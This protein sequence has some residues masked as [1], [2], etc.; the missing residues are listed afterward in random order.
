MKK[1]GKKATTTVSKKAPTVVPDKVES[2]ENT[3]PFK[4]LPISTQTVMAYANCTFNINNIFDNLPV[5]DIG[6]NNIKKVAG[7]HGKIYQLK[8]AGEVRGAPTKKGHFRNQITAYIYVIDK[9]ITAKI[10]PTGKFHLTGCKNVKHQQQAVVEL[11]NHIR[12]IHSDDTP[13]ITMEGDSPL[14][15]ILEVVM[16]N[17][18][19]HLG[20]N[21]DQRKLDHLLQSEGC[22]FYTIF[23][24]PVNTSVNIKLDYPDP[25]D[26]KYNQVIIEGPVEKPKVTLTTTSEC[27][28][29]KNSKTRTHTFLVFS[30]S[31]VIQSGRYY[32]SEM[33]PAYQKFHDFIVENKDQIELQLQDRD[34]DMSLLKGINS[35][36]PLKMSRNKKIQVG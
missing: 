1:V 2:S 28:K 4:A 12:C 31:K 14:N 5:E 27:Q 34:F 15:V 10:F 23:E 26:K 19:F 13:A 8:R 7:E 35:N 16:V 3:R 21:V 29:A 18:D 36:K 30:S 11:I 25:T 22:D 33:E 6:D 9:M 17:V 24:T 20:F 32:D